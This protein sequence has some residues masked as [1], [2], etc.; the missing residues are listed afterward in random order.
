LNNKR[1]KSFLVLSKTLKE[2]WIV[3]H[4]S[5]LR[6]LHAQIDASASAQAKARIAREI[7]EKSEQGYIVE[8]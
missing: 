8:K 4:E 1:V 3:G 7:K 2:Y 5:N 6:S